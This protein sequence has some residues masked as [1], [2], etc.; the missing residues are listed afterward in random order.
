MEARVDRAPGLPHVGL[1]Y[2]PGYRDAVLREFAPTAAVAMAFLLPN[3]P[4]RGA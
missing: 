4:D 3:P 2:A 1:I